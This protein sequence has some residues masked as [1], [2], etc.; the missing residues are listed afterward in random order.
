MADCC[1]SGTGFP[2]APDMAARAA[3]LPAIWE[4]ICKIQQAILEA[5]NPCTPCAK[6]GL[7]HNGDGQLCTTVGGDTPMTFIDGIT[8]ID[9]ING[10]QGYVTDKPFAKIIPPNGGP[11]S[12]AAAT[13]VTNGS[14][15]LAINVTAGGSGYQ[16][17]HSTMTVTSGTG[18]GADLQPLVNASGRLIGVSVMSGGTGYTLNDIVTANRA[19]PP[20][21][22]YR[23]ATFRITSVGPNGEI[24]GVQVIHC[25]IGYQDS[26]ATVEIVSSLDNT[27]PYPTGTGFRGLV[28]T[29]PSGVITGIMVANGGQGYGDMTPYLVINDPGTGAVTKVNVENGVVTSIDVLK[30]GT[31]YTKDAT[32]TVF[33]PPGAPLPNPPAVPAIVKINVKENPYCTDPTLYYKVWAGTA[34]NKAIQL[35]INTVMSYFKGLGYTIMAQTNP[36]S[37]NTLQWKVCW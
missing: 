10:G 6:T 26:T 2:K 29:D 24:T 33:N 3:N 28:V 11:G 32:G 18:T 34:T 22:M 25:G 14:E 27:K 23:D 4:E 21:P 7:C 17:I 13:V 30:S 1:E 37:G 31:G 35:Q 8:S 5:A 20:N 9:V 36:E 16:P 19:I 12:G 15:I